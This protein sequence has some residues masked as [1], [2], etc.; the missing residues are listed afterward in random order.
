[1]MLRLSD[2]VSG[3]YGEPSTFVRQIAIV[4]TLLKVKPENIVVSTSD[5]EHWI[6]VETLSWAVRSHANRSLEGYHRHNVDDF[7]FVY[8]Y[9][10]G[11][12][13]VIFISQDDLAKHLNKR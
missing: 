6:Q 2:L 5:D 4:S 7:C 11:G 3:E 9:A 1:M 10:E 12:L 8:H 13:S